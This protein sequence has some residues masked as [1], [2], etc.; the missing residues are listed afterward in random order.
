MITYYLPAG[1]EGPCSLHLAQ[2]LATDVNPEILGF[3]AVIFL[4]LGCHLA[5]TGT[6]V[7][8]TW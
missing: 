6:H 3:P 8:L 4:T 7:M 5:H 2:V 1:A